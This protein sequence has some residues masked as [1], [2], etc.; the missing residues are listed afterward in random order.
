MDNK[1]YMDTMCGK[2]QK[3][4]Q[5][6]SNTIDSA[7]TKKNTQWPRWKKYFA[8]HPPVFWPSVILIIWAVV[9]TLVLW[10]QAEQFFSWLQ[11]SITSSTGWLLILTVNIFLIFL[12]YLATSRFGSIRLWWA[13]AKPE[14][15]WSSWFA[16]LFSAWMGIGIIFWSVAE[17]VFHYIAPPLWSWESLQ[18]IQTAMNMTFL[19]R[20]FHAWGIYAV[21][22]LSL[23]FFAFNW[24]LPLSFRSV[25]YPLIGERI[26]GW[27][28][29]CIDILAVLATL[30]WL[31]TSLWFWVIQVSAW[32]E[33]VFWIPDTSWLQVAVIIWVTAIA[34]ISVVLWIKKWV[35]RLSRFNLRVAWLFLLFIL[36]AGP[37]LFIING[38]VQNIW[39]YIGTLASISFGTDAYTWSDRQNTRTIFYRAWWI[40]WSPYVG[41]FIAKISKWR[42]IREFLL[43]VLLVPSFLTFL[44]MTAFWW[45][46]IDFIREWVSTIVPAIEEN[47]A[48]AL[49]VFLEQFPRSDIISYV[50]IILIL[51]FFVTSSDSWSLVVDW[52]TTGWKLD[53]PVW[54]RIFRAQMEGLVAAVL[55]VWW[56]L[57]A[58]QTASITTWLPFAI[59]LLVM[60]WSLYRGVWREDQKIQ[61]QAND[62]NR[63]Y[64]KQLLIE[65]LH[66]QEN[67]KNNW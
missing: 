6:D 44:W 53:A 50:A 30:F 4:D 60:C 9:A 26:Y 14:F 36:V 45:V 55:L 20:W 34:T 5:R 52:L 67:K 40:S 31:A 47:V 15:S 23:A 29:D 27:I 11:N 16:M 61:Q 2:E 25:F 54:Q 56:W 3:H 19:H 66:T 13:D 24:K 63:A 12:I 62:E 46:A 22:A 8:I 33:H 42:T 59:I 38:F 58:L 10:E 32:L 7:D 57:W 28:G 48:T 37:T 18:A 64:Y 65:T 43:G 17:P 1:W 35:R 51:S 41:M 39:W 49:F 21:V